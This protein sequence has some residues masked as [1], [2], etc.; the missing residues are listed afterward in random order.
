M[1]L[2]IV[3]VAIIVINAL[4]NTG[5]FKNTTLLEERSRMFP[6][7]AEDVVV[8]EPSNEEEQKLK[9]LSFTWKYD[10]Q[11]SKGQES[12]RLFRPGTSR[13]DCYTFLKGVN[14]NDSELRKL[15][16]DLG[17]HWPYLVPMK[18]L[19]EKINST[20]PTFQGVCSL[21]VDIADGSKL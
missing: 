6:L 16:G 2:F 21:S 20:S 4:Q 7:E 15:I 11:N 13:Q 1:I 12:T 19:P 8:F 17:S 9:N 18:T 14:A 10:Y 5:D 3:L